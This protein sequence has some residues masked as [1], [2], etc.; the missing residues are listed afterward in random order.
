MWDTNAANFSSPCGSWLASTLVGFGRILCFVRQ[1]KRLGQRQ[2]L[3]LPDEVPPEAG[4]RLFA[5]Q[6]NASRLIDA[7]GGDQHVVGP[8]ADLAVVPLAGEADALGD[9]PAADSEPA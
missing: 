4:V 7:A 6:A 8:E 5:H 9:E 1:R 2:F 3:E